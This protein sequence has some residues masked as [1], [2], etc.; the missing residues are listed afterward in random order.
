MTSDTQA[1]LPP[2]P[3]Q[4]TRRVTY[5]WLSRHI[6]GVAVL[7]P[8]LSAITAMVAGMQIGGLDIVRAFSSLGFPIGASAAMA[9]ALVWTYLIFL[10]K[11][12]ADEEQR[13]QLLLDQH[14]E[15]R[16]AFLDTTEGITRHLQAMDEKLSMLG[17]R[18]E[19]ITG[20]RRQTPPVGTPRG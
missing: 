1:A 6:G 4:R 11:M 15:D 8:L 12:L 20:I 3:S 9:V 7:G 5:P 10:P 2:L 17:Q 14:A 13:R 19:A 18:V 16:R